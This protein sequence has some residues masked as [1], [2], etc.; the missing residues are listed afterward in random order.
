M[1]LE[2]LGGKLADVGKALLNELHSVLVHLIKV[3]RGVEEPVPPVKAQ[4]VDVLLDSLHELH[5]LLGGVGVV[6]PQI[7]QPTILLRRTKV[8]DQGLAVA[9][10]EVA[11]GLRRKTGMDF[12]PGVLSAGSDVLINKIVD[13][14]LCHDRLHFFRHGPHAPSLL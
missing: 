12:H 9:D 4:P 3:V 13:K 6:H 8:D 1:G 2:F 7:A 11:V 10:M 5:V 14:I